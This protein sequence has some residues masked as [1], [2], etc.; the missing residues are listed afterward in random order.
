MPPWRK[1]SSVTSTPNQRLS[2]VSFGYLS[3]FYSSTRYTWF[4]LV[5]ASFIYFFSV[6]RFWFLYLVNTKT[7]PTTHVYGWVPKYLRGKYCQ[8]IKLI[9]ASM[10]FP[11]YHIYVSISFW[12]YLFLLKKQYNC[13]EKGKFSRS[14]LQCRCLIIIYWVN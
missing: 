4:Q 5:N 7:D 12:I 6:M 13:Q 11:T 3:W 2:K 14:F 1:A 10:E 8:M 9:I